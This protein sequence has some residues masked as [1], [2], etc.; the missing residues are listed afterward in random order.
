MFAATMRY[1]S[2][3]SSEGRYSARYVWTA[4]NSADGAKCEAKA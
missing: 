1:G 4:A 3:L 2:G